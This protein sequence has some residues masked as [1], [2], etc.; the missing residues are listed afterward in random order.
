MSVRTSP[1]FS[2]PSPNLRNQQ[3]RIPAPAFQ[4]L[5]P[6]AR[7]TEGR[8]QAMTNLRM[9]IGEASHQGGSP[10]LLPMPEAEQPKKMLK[11]KIEP[12]MYMKT[13]DRLT[14]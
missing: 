3:G 5:D 9:P 14:Q 8:L 6:G 7:A 13:K 10:T 1:P 4:R 12:E 11:M 2:K